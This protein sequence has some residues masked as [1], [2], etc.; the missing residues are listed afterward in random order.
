MTIRG[1]SSV[2]RYVVRLSPE[3]RAQLEGFK[4]MGKIPA[5]RLTKV[6]I[7]LKADVS[8]AGEGWRDTEIVRFGG[9]ALLQKVAGERDMV[10]THWRCVHE[11][12]I[13]HVFAGV[14]EMRHGVGYIGRVPIHDGGDYEIEP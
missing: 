11:Q 14:A 4:N 7:L 6:L 2:N 3:E 1:I 5:R 12:F 9:G 10:P 13:G 8:E